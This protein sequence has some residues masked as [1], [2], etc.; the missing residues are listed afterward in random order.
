MLQH[1]KMLAVIGIALFAF[2]GPALATRMLIIN[3]DEK[4]S[5][6]GMIKHG[7]D[8]IDIRAFA[9]KDRDLVSAIRKGAHSRKIRILIDT[10]SP[11]IESILGFKNIEI[12][13]T[14]QTRRGKFGN[15]LLAKSCLIE[16]GRGHYLQWYG[17][18][19]WASGAFGNQIRYFSGSGIGPGQTFGSTAKTFDYEFSLAQK[20]SKPAPATHSHKPFLL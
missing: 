4:K 8:P 10:S 6:A 20:L 12:R 9:I 3:Y 5:L 1:I 19:T 13:V 18:L 11:E 16:R 15:R 17:S 14:S 7:A 2:S